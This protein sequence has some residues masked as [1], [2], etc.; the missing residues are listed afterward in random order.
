MCGMRQ[1]VHSSRQTEGIEG[2]ALTLNRS[3]P[4]EA[5]KYLGAVREWYCSMHGWYGS[6]E[7]YM[8]MAVHTRT[9]SGRAAPT[10]ENERMDARTYHIVDLPPHKTWSPS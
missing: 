10:Y 8:C 9:N 4:S 5:E 3:I 1:A 7:S 2:L 6:T